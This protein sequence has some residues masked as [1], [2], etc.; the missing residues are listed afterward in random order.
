[1]NRPM[2]LDI[3]YLFWLPCVCAGATQIVALVN[4]V[5][6]WLAFVLFATVFVVVF[7]APILRVWFFA[8]NGNGGQDGPAEEE[9]DAECPSRNGVTPP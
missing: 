5:P 3:V 4:G 8:G 9:A 6:P 2:W 7:L 1:M